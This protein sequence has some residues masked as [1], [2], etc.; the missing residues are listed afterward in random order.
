MFFEMC[1]VCLLSCLFAISFIYT[2]EHI[3]KSTYIY[4]TK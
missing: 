2:K 1:I 4:Y 3:M